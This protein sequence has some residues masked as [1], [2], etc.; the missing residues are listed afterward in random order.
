MEAQLWNAKQLR[1]RLDISESTFHRWKR[2]GWLRKFETKQ[3]MGQRRYSSVRVEEYLK[4]RSTAR[5]GP[6][7]RG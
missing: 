2:L 6:G 3:P 7:A 1:N 5:V 4:A